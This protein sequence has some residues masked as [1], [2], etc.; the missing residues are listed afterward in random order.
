MS[1]GF[2]GA[3]DGS[4]GFFPKT[5]VRLYD[6]SLKDAP[7]EGEVRERR[8]LQFKVSAME[9]L[10]VAHGTVGIKEAISRLRGM[11]DRD[12]TRLPLFGG[13]PG[14]EAEWERWK[15]AVDA[16]EEVEKSL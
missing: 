13:I 8:L 3:I 7:S 5:L 14:G 16:V 1:V 9:E 6:L 10:V 4:A 2:A 12:G 15:G 11:G